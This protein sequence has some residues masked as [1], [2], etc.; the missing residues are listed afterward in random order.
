MLCSPWMSAEC[1]IEIGKYIWMGRTGE[2]SPAARFIPRIL[3]IVDTVRF[4]ESDRFLLRSPRESLRGECQRVAHHTCRGKG[5][6]R[7]SVG[8]TIWGAP[9]C[10]TG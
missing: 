10:I 3:L 8:G 6:N 5:S 9:R 7:D 4:H 2:D 1:G